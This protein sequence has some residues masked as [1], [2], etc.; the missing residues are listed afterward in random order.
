MV[1]CNATLVAGTPTEVA[2]EAEAWAAEGFGTFKLKL[3]TGD[4][5]GQVRAVRE[6]LGQEAR[7][8]VDANASW[9]VEEAARV[10]EAIEPYAI[11]LVEQPVATLEEMA[12]LAARTQT[13]QL[14]W[15]SAY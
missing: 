7:I 1:R 15:L 11:E 10:L 6:A 13:W 14:P 8:R 3:G 5:A 12:E 9:R 4:D 2:V